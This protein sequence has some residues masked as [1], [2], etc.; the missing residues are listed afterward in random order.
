MVK[1]IFHICIV[2]WLI[3]ISCMTISRKGI[4][5][6]GIRAELYR[7]QSAH[8]SGTGW[9]IRVKLPDGWDERYRFDSIYFKGIPLPCQLT[10]MGQTLEANYFIGT[11]REPAFP[12]DKIQG[13]ADSLVSIFEN[14]LQPSFITGQKGGRKIII[15]ISSFTEMKD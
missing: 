6:N 10:D 7:Y 15:R 5:S 8:G 9:V 2:M 1:S 4:Q 3:L 12:E 11:T 13:K 14:N